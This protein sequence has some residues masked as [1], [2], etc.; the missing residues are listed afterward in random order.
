[1]RK[2]TRKGLVR[3]LDKLVGDIVKQRDG[4][5][6]TCGSHSDLQPGHLFSRV[7][8][9]TRW[10]LMNV[11]CQCRS[12]NLRHEYDPYPL[13]NYFIEIWGRKKLDELHFKYVHPVKFKDFQL[14]EL[15][16]NLHDTLKG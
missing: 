7:A 14:Q 15:Y 4:I 10:D 9:S 6:T 3:K 8:Y 2:I 11:Y 5:C 1:M 16:D 12:C 13:T